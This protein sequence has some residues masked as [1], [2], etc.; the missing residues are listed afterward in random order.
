MVT[1]PI[2]QRGYKNPQLLAETDC[3]RNIWAIPSSASSM[4]A[5]HNNTRPVISRCGEP[6][7]HERD[8]TDC[9]RRDG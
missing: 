3:S 8:S 7:R 4:R 2:L 9:R 5:R 1:F 6:A